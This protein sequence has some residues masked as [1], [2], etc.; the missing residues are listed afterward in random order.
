MLDTSTSLYLEYAPQKD[1]AGTR[2]VVDS[3][4]KI[5]GIYR[6][7]RMSVSLGH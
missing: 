2:S 6:G 5:A 4:S 7:K 1:F 3:D